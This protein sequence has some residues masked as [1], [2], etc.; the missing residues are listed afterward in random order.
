MTTAPEILQAGIDAMADRAVTRDQPD[1]ERSMARAVAIYQ[2]AKGHSELS[3]ERD[4][5][6]FMVCLKLA[7]AEGGGHNLDDYVDGAAYFVVPE[8]SLMRPRPAS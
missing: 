1:G 7:R 4:G 8:D 3:D 5:W 2:A 6:L